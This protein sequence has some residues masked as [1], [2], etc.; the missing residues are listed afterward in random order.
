MLYLT[1][2]RVCCDR[3][4]AGSVCGEVLVEKCCGVEHG[5]CLLGERSVSFFEDGPEGCAGSGVAEFLD[6]G[7]D[8][9][10]SV[11]PLPEESDHSG[12]SHVVGIVA[13]M[14]RAR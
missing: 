6:D 2:L 3:P 13:A 7:L 14:L 12:V 4:W 1:L 5:S 11:M 9:G 10:E 8:A